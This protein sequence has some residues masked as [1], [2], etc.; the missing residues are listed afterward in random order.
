MITPKV[1]KP[2]VAE[3]VDAGELVEVTV[4]GWTEPGYAVPTAR[5]KQPTRTT[6]TLLS[7]FDSLIWERSRA[8]RLF[9]FDYRI[10][11]Y[12]PEPEA[13]ARLLRPAAAP[14]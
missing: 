11:V 8:L 12:V 13:E 5:P 3:L 1:A 2:R 9:G 4:E 10:E 7:P 14:R 6:A